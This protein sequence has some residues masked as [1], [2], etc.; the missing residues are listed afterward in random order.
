MQEIV[1]VKHES[2]DKTMQSMKQ[3]KSGQNWSKNVFSGWLLLLSTFVSANKHGWP[4]AA[5]L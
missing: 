4:K 3:T 5:S 1:A 2:L